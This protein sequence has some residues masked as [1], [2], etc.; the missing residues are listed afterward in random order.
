MSAEL[1][2][3]AD[4][5]TR[6]PLDLK[7]VGAY[8]YFEDPR[9]DAWCLTWAINDEPIELW[10]LGEPPPARLNQAIEDGA[11]FVA[12]NNFFE[13][14]LFKLVLGPRYGFVVPKL[15]QCYCT[16]AAAAAMALPRDLAGVAY[17]LGLEQQKDMLGRRIM[18]QCARPRVVNPD[19]TI[20]WWDSHP[21]GPAKLEILYDYC[22]TDTAVERAVE[23]HVRPLSEFERRVWLLDQAINERGVPVD[24]IA[25]QHA[26]WVLYHHAEG[27]GQRLRTITGG[28]VATANQV[29]KIV[30]WLQAQGV[31]VEK[32]DRNVVKR[33]LDGIEGDVT[34][35]EIEEAVNE[36]IDT[37]DDGA[38]R[39]CKNRDQIREVLE[40]RQELSKSSTKK[41]EAFTERCSQDRRARDNL[42]YFA[43]S[44]GRWGAR[45]IQ[46]HNMP[47]KQTKKVTD[48]KTGRLKA[49]EL[50]TN[51]EV[52]WAFDLLVHRDPDVIERTLGSPTIVMADMLKGFIK[53]QPGK[54]LVKGDY[55]N[56]EG[57]VAAWLAEETWKVKAFEAADRKEGPDIYLL[58]GSKIAGCHVSEL[59]KES[60]ER[61][62]GKVGELACI[63]EDEL[64]LTDVGLVPIQDVTRAMR[65]WDG[66]EFVLHDGVVFRGT[67]EVITHDGLTATRDHLVWTQAHGRPL[68]FE[69]AAKDGAALLKSGAGRQALRTGGDHRTAAPVHPRGLVGIVHTLPLHRMRRREVDR[70]YQSGARK[71]Q[72][73]LP[74]RATASSGTLGYQACDSHEV[75]LQQS[76]RSGLPELRWARHPLQVQVDVG[77]CALGGGQSRFAPGLGVGPHRQQR[78]LRAGQSE[79]LHED[80][81]DAQPATRTLNAIRRRL[82]EIRQRVRTPRHAP[83]SRTGLPKRSDHRL[84]VQ[85]RARKAKELAGYSEA[86]R[87]ARVYDVINAGPRH[88]F[89]VSNALVHNCQFGGSVGALQTMAAVY[90]VNFTNEFAKEVV[91]A[92][93][94]AHPA[95]VAYWYRLEEAILHV[96]RNGGKATIGKVAFAFRQGFLWARKPN[97]ELL[98]Y[99]DPRIRMTRRIINTKTG[100]ARSEIA[101]KDGVFRGSPYVDDLIVQHMEEQNGAGRWVIQVPEHEAVTVMSVNSQTRKWERVGLYGGLIFENFVQAIARDCMVNGMFNLEDA[102]YPIILTVHDEIISEVDREFGSAKQFEALMVAPAPWM[103]GLPIRAEADECIRYRK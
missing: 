103:A 34:E 45:G 86:P 75:A 38:Y 41:L 32:L 37:G 51:E 48:P 61:Q 56:I 46:L 90:D 62:W 7:K 1:T 80:R 33:T 2:I 64:V 99:V 31:D 13:R 96:V 52:E 94:D 67:K 73:L 100:M 4:A 65:V 69:E 76:K 19:G 72:G 25:V 63:A 98:C 12:H 16:A 36:A 10:K 68:P 77:M 83:V 21:D 84:G 54:K 60:P 50:L 92:W 70:A 95:I 22:R 27:L 97:G 58:T 91:T 8:K 23:K 30:E 15:E 71:E 79:V 57:R 53:A 55:S 28:A 26:R 82:G 24:V 87:F 6:S 29:G 66:V 89:T 42:M 81:A 85:S 74:L 3:H 14:M 20:L 78:S 93:R 88:R 102:G 9:T 44:T 101:D 17:A 49:V 35:E 18:L 39:R 43:A 40:I 11:R 47:R 59:T 5:E